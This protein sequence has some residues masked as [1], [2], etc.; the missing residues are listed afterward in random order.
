MTMTMTSM[1][2]CC[3]KFDAAYVAHSTLSHDVFMRSRCQL[4]KTFVNKEVTHSF[5]PIACHL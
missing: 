4:I 1:E 3:S 2:L 5:S